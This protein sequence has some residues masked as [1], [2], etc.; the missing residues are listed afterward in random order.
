MT[1]VCMGD[2]ITFGYGVDTELTWI[3]TLSKK[4][5]YK[6]INKGIPGN[7]TA[8]MLERFFED[9]I[10]LSPST[11]LIL[12]GT[13]DVFLNKEIDEVFFNLKAMIDLCK[14]HHICPIILTPLPVN[15]MIKEKIWFKDVDFKAVNKKLLAL[16]RL[17]TDY[18]HKENITLIDLGN[19]LIN[20]INL[21]THYL[22]D[23]IHVTS[24]VH[25]EIANIIFEE[26]D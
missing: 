21:T 4:T 7:T 8:Q 10:Q 11:A 9:V 12:G 15:E 18:C 25:S 26:I 14:L 17:L 6:I 19:I 3:S 22:E 16:R 1:M 13:N 23:G 20:R 24:F 5:N 2:S